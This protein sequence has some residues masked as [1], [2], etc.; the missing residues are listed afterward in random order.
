MGHDYSKRT[1]KLLF[2]R[3]THCAFPDPACMTPLIFE[4]RGR[5]TVSADIAHIRSESEDGPRYDPDYPEPLIDTEENLLLL[6]GLHHRP[7]DHHESV[8]PIEELLEWKRR[9]V[10]EARTARRFSDEQIAQ[11]AGQVQSALAALYEVR[12]TVQPVGLIL[13]AEGFVRTPLLSLSEVT[14]TGDLGH[15]L[16]IEVV[17]EGLVPVSI[18]AVG[19]DVDVDARDHISYHFRVGEWAPPFGAR[20]IESKATALYPA[21]IPTV[22]GHIVD[23]ARS[24]SRVPRRFKT[25]AEGAGAR[26]DGLWLPV[27]D[28]PVWKPGMTETKLEAMRTSAAARRDRLD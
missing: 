25:F 17:N 21:D 8:Y 1:L 3:A 26:E 2:G 19:I 24:R 5:L 11:I 10:A 22:S 12:L 7:V 6:C 20:R 15:Y 4:H 27:L 9:Q 14:V 23:V 13:T 16:G 28:L 18:D